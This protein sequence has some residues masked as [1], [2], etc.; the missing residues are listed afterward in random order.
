MSAMLGN[1]VIPL[2]AAQE[3]TLRGGLRKML[4][5]MIVLNVLYA[6]CVGY[7]YRFS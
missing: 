1:L 7:A 5:M 4:L 2:I 3:R 6:L